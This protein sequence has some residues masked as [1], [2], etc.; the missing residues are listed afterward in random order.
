MAP[1]SATPHPYSRIE[2]RAPRTVT[3]SIPA[4]KTRLAHSAAPWSSGGRAGQIHGVG[5]P[6][7]ARPRRAPR[8]RSAQSRRRSR[9][10]RRR[11][12]DRPPLCRRRRAATRGRRREDG[13]PPPQRPADRK[14]A[15]V[16]PRAVT[17]RSQG[18]QRPV[19]RSGSPKG[20]TQAMATTRPRRP[21]AAAG[22][23]AARRRPTI[24]SASAAPP[25]AG[26]RRRPAPR[27][28]RARGG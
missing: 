10:A 15:A 18:S 4:A 13:R 20:L 11:R 24:S 5:Q 21:Q 17:K 19:A 7:P 28:S 23:R 25:P 26:H 12:A 6:L 16:R 8:R 9:P 3:S 22:R 27:A 14:A 2:S 1:W